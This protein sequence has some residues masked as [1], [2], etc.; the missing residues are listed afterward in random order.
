MNALSRTAE[1]ALIEARRNLSLE[2]LIF[3][4]TGHKIGKRS[5]CP[6]CS[7]KGKFGC[8]SHGEARLYKCFSTNCAA[9]TSGD[10][11]AF[12]M[13]WENLDRK[14]AFKRLLDLAGV[15]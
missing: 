10:D 15:S 2:D 3:R 5:D 1:E 12:I 13:L 4:L 11:I 8:F 9:H 6:V 7:R 14:A